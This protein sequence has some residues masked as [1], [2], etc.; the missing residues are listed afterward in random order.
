MDNVGFGSHVAFGGLLGYALSLVFA[1]L[2]RLD[3]AVDGL[4]LGVLAVPVL[5]WAATHA[6]RRVNAGDVRSAR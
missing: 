6:P 5:T 4:V 1:A 2:G 3:L